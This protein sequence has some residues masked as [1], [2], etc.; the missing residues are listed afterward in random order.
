MKRLSHRLSRMSSFVNACLR[1]YDL[2]NEDMARFVEK[3]KSENSAMNSQYMQCIWS[4]N[5]L[6][7]HL[8]NTSYARKQRKWQEEDERLAQKDLENPNDKFRGWL[9][10][11]ILVHSKLTGLG[12]VTF[13]RQSPSELA[14][15]A[16]RESSKDSNDERKNNALTKAL[17]TK[18]QWG[19]VHGVSNKL[20]WKEGF[21][22][23]KSMY[24]NRKTI[25]TPHVDVEELKR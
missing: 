9:E 5:E 4:Q 16:V 11:F 12:D 7:H 21:P 25:L 22:E 15:R 23:Q 24:R 8:G 10:P 19:R 2:S 3:C 20:T 18:E 14:Q 6:D 1:L 13:Y 17:Q